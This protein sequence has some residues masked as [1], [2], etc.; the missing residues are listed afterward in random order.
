MGIAMAVRE[1]DCLLCQRKYSR[2]TADAIFPANQL[3]DDC[4]AE[5]NQ[6]EGDDLRARIAQRLA[7]RA[8]PGLA[9]AVM[10]AIQT[11]KQNATKFPSPAFQRKGTTQ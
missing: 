9:E 5:L 6:L 4:L 1:F 8:T 10:A 7:E 3:C 11:Y 2:M